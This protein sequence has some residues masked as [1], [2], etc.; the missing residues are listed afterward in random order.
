MGFGVASTVSPTPKNSS[1]GELKKQVARYVKMPNDP[2]ALSIAAD[3]INDGIRELNLRVWYW[4]LTYQD[5]TLVAEQ[6]DYSTNQDF[7]AGFWAEFLK[8]N[9]DPGGGCAQYDPDT[10][11][12]TYPRSTQ[13]GKPC[14]YTV[15]NHTDTSTLSLNKKPN[16]AFVNEYPTLRLRYFRRHQLLTQDGDRIVG[17]SEAELFLSWYAKWI[18]AT[19]FDPQLAVL[20]E[21]QKEITWR[22]LRVD[23]NEHHFHNWS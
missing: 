13:S 9:G 4:G 23:D 8:S 1:L 6:A 17:P 15:I 10:F 12:K 11:W 19:T 14:A 22:K 3:A 7:K 16:S 18:L 21:R 2:E 20:A 5:I